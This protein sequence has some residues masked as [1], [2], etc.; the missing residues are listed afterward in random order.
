MPDQNQSLPGT[1]DGAARAAAT[2]AAGSTGPMTIDLTALDADL[3]AN[4][5]IA[6]LAG[7]PVSKA[8]RM[9]ADAEAMIGR[10]G[11]ILP[12]GPDDQEGLAAF[13]K[14]IGVPETPDQYPAPPLP[15]G[16]VADEATDKQ[17]RAWALEL[18]WTPQ[19]YTG[20]AQRI[21]DW[22]V[23]TQR[24]QQQQRAASLEAARAAL[25]TEWGPAYDA[26]VQQADGFLPTL[27]AMVR[28]PST[29]VNAAAESVPSML[30]GGAPP[31]QHGHGG[32]PL[33]RV[34]QGRKGPATRV[35]PHHRA[36]AEPLPRRP[37]GQDRGRERAV[38]QTH[39]RQPRGPRL[40]G[41]PRHLRARHR[42][43]QAAPP[44]GHARRQARPRRLPNL[45]VGCAY[46]TGESPQADPPAIQHSADTIGAGLVG[47]APS[48]SLVMAAPKEHFLVDTRGRRTGVVIPLRRYAALMEDL[49]DLAVVAERREDEPSASK[50]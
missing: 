7:Q 20:F 36:G 15:E 2:P 47:T 39:F 48:G 5:T 46:P 22:N 45:P 43:A 35:G 50:K 23:A 8:L 14:A 32:A 27:G 42:D 18:G 34:P 25:R 16:L 9:L 1:T 26:Q 31:P 19:Q 49:H 11:V 3:A 40:P 12:K 41:R 17:L 4:K 21:A 13:R 6:A 29:I 44:H 10:K 38:R 24:Q 28:N 37:A 30:A 33:R